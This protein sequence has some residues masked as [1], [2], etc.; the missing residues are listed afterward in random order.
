MVLKLR[1]PSVRILSEGC[2]LCMPL[3]AIKTDRLELRGLDRQ[4]LTNFT[5]YFFD[6][7]HPFYD[8]LT[9]VKPRFSL[10]S[11]T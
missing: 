2:F 11:I 5:V 3:H 6:I 4:R 10:I 9:P 1:E 7:G 8:Q